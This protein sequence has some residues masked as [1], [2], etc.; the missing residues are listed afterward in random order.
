M[1]EGHARQQ[2]HRA[3]EHR[4]GDRRG[5]VD[6]ALQAAQVEAVELGVRDERLQHGGHQ[7]HVGHALALD[8]LQH[9]A[10]IEGGGQHMR[11]AGD[12]L[13]QRAADAAHVEQRRHVQRDAALGHGCLRKALD[14]DGPQRPVAVHHALGETGGAAGVE[15]AGQ[16]VAGAVCVFNRR[17]GVD[18]RGQRRHALGRAALACV[19]EDR[20]PF[21]A[22]ADAFDAVEKMVVDHEDAGVAVVQRVD[23]LGHAPARVDGVEHAA[24]PPDA[25]QHFEPAV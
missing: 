24:A 2:G 15:D 14:A 22:G 10:R 5:A 18:E 1:R 12:E 6:H 8:G 23:D 19:E 11:F 17:G 7:Q 4:L 13:H 25:H 16:V 3:F 21:G 9:L 20:R